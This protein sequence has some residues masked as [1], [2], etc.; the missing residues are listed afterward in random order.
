M[1]MTN[2]TNTSI[3]SHRDADRPL[4]HLARTLLGLLRPGIRRERPF[5]RLSLEERVRLALGE[6]P[7]QRQQ[8][9]LCP[10]AIRTRR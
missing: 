7:A 10:V 2:E 3:S 9:C 5:D 1:T 6:Y 4:R 8:A